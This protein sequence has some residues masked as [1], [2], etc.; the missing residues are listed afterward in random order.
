VVAVIGDLGV[1][2]AGALSVFRKLLSPDP[3]HALLRNVL[4]PKAKVASGIAL[5]NAG[6]VSGLMDSSDGLG[7]TFEDL[8]R[9]SD[10]RF[11]LTMTDDALPGDVR[12]VADRLGVE[13]WRLALGWGDW[14]LV[15]TISG[16]A[17][18]HARSVVAATGDEMHV[19]GEVVPGQ[20]VWLRYGRLTGRLNAPLSERFAKDSWFTAGIESYITTI[21]SA[22]LVR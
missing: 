2:W 4:L 3:G 9:A 11:D 5:H 20:G 1:F 12:E 18:E 8:A 7:S 22:P 15:A 21:M 19:I 6:V 14:Q 17:V 10:V 16:D 13:P